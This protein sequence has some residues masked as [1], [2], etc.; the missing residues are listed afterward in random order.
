MA[1]RDPGLAAAAFA[2]TPRTQAEHRD[3]Q[4][5]F[6]GDGGDG[7]DES[8]TTL[9]T[10]LSS[11]MRRLLSRVRHAEDTLPEDDGEG[12]ESGSEEV[13]DEMEALRR[14]LRLSR[15]ETEE[16]RARNQALAQRLAVVEKT[17]RD[18]REKAR[19]ERE[20][21]VR[22]N[23]SLRELV[24]SATARTALA[25]ERAKSMKIKVTEELVVRQLVSPRSRSVT[26]RSVQ[27]RRKSTVALEARVRALE[28][29]MRSA[30][31]ETKAKVR[32]RMAQETGVPK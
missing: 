6:G 31:K 15:R 28:H 14:E 5:T 19:P 2:F 11:D 32:R 21:I 20:E 24:Q 3:D 17:L 29:R 23:D 9:S 18:E 26:P 27:D 30:D 8:A 22:N 16:L 7:D 1:A 10:N 13:V 25:E 12:S 4:F